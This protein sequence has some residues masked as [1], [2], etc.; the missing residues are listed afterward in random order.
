MVGMTWDGKFAFVTNPIEQRLTLTGDADA[1]L[2]LAV[3]RTSNVK[4]DADAVSQELSTDTITCT[5]RAVQE[6]LKKLKK[7]AT[8]G[9]TCV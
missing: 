5:P 1:K 8:E 2:L 9:T 7:V 4:I 6:R 3:L